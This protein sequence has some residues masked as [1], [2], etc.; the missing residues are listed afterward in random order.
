MPSDAGSFLGLV[1]GKLLACATLDAVPST[2]SAVDRICCVPLWHRNHTE[3]AAPANTMASSDRGDG[4]ASPDY[5]PSSHYVPPDSFH[6][7]SVRPPD[8]LGRWPKGQIL[9]LSGTATTIHIQQTR[10]FAYRLTSFC[11]CTIEGGV[12]FER[13]LHKPSYVGFLYT[14]GVAFERRLHKPCYI[15]FL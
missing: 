8:N 10:E 4:G 12:A 6:S 1:L 9:K 15:G 2:W 3:D 7:G 14:V 11:S 13:N 5:C